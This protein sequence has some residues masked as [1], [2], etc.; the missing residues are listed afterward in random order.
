MASSPTTTSQGQKNTAVSGSGNTVPRLLALVQGEPRGMGAKETDQKS[1]FFY[2]HPHLFPR[3]APS[4]GRLTTPP[5]HTPTH[6]TLLL[7]S[8]IST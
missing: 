5:P 3:S 8:L 6:M 1:R 2:C 4:R 7:S